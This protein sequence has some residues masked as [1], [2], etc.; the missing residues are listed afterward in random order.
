[1]E[2]IIVSTVVRAPRARV[3]ETWTDPA[4]VVHWYFASDDWH[5][6]RAE[7]DLRVGGRFVTEMAARDGSAGF[8]FEG[9]YTEVLP[10]ERIGYVM[11]DGR[12]VTIAF[13]DKDGGTEVTETFDPETENTI[14]LQRH[15]WQSILDNFKKYAEGRTS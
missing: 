11:D 10:Q 12:K 1:M 14:E 7:N 13:A 3:W 9:T 8:D 5:V 2:K 15:G 4:H 6:P